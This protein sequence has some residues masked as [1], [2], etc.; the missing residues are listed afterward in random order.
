MYIY[1]RTKCSIAQMT[2]TKEICTKAHT[3]TNA[4][5]QA[6]IFRGLRIRNML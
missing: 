4:Q 2:T 3:I 5:T 1:T 6:Q